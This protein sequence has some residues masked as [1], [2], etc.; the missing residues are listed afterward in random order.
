MSA[1]DVALGAAPTVLDIEK[2]RADFP[3]LH[4]EVNG[5]KLVYLDN[6]ASAHKPQQ[7]IDV[8]SEG[9]GGPYSNV[10]RGVH[11]LSQRAT[12]R[13]EAA[14]ETSRAFLGAERDD[15]IVFVRG[16]TEGINL[17]A[18]SFVRP[19]LEAGDEIIV[20]QMEHHSNIVP[21]QLL[22]EETG[23]VLKVVP[24]DDRGQL[25][26]DVYADLLGERT[27]F[28]AMVHVSN[29][30][31]TINPAKEIVRLAKQHGVPVLFDGAQAAPHTKIDVQALGCDFYVVSS[32]KLF[33]P[34]GI[35]ALYGR[36]ELLESMLPYQGG[37]EMILSVSFTEGTT[38]NVPPHRFEA[39]TPHIVGAQGMAAAMEYITELGHDAIEAH[40]HDLLVYAT[41]RLETLDAVRIVGTAEDKASVVSFVVDG[42]H[43]HDLGTILDHEGVAIRAGHHCA[44]PVMDRYGLPA[45]ARASFAFYNT[46]AEVDTLVDALG[47][48]IDMFT[49]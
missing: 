33:G 19:R 24:I 49:L 8:L 11:T 5:K 23:A 20:S 26:M 47:V 48:A 30:L 43:P 6:A 16:A 42:V 31:G 17:V 35:G 15:E 29:A 37:G 1:A 46:R 41:E 12:D 4:Q 45:T 32:H 40:E 10:H 14:R 28:V 36:Y 7:V 21:W 18:W 25:D 34:T 27:R 44:Q 38:Y 22:C 2:V 9:Y 3:A 13:Y 39:G